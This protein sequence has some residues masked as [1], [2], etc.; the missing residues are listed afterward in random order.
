MARL[1]FALE[2][3]EDALGL[4]SRC[5]HALAAEVGGRAMPP[6]KIHL[7]LAFLGEVGDAQAAVAEEAAAAVAARPFTLVLD[8]FGSFRRA[9]V[10]WAGASAPP[11]ELGLLQGSLAV[12]L[13]ARGF[14][15]EPRPF[16]P[17]VT[18][19]RKVERP[20][21]DAVLA[22]VAW[23]VTDFGLVRSNLGTGKYETVRRWPLGTA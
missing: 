3:E 17:H 22:P 18:L 1:F 15:L 14:A 20:M 21:R 16:A 5:A 13:E 2:P 10:A 12:Q 19:V 4:L 6:D 9:G 11:P 23:R 8:R 7:T